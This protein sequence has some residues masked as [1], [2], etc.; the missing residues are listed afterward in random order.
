MQA[1]VWVSPVCCVGAT[2]AEDR[3]PANALHVHWEHAG[4]TDNSL[5]QIT[6]LYGGCQ[7]SG[8]SAVSLHAFQ[9]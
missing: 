8:L 6:V 1:E 2:C 5:T 7:C 9:L 3:S 4:Q